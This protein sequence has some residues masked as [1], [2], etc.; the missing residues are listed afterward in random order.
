MEIMGS[1]P[2]GQHQTRGAGRGELD[3]GSGFCQRALGEQRQKGRA[4]GRRDYGR[5]QSDAM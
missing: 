5:A 2:G 3:P 1:V 4:R